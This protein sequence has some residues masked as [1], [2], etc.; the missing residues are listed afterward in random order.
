MEN[1]Y[2]YHA[3]HRNDGALC[4]HMK[5]IET[6]MFFSVLATDSPYGSDLH[7]S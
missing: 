6:R 7:L 5:N 3:K 1:E 4:K 2:R